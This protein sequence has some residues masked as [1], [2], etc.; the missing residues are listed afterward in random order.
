[1]R[2][3]TITSAESAGGSEPINLTWT[4]L[5]LQ[6]RNLRLRR[7]LAFATFALSVAFAGLVALADWRITVAA[8][9]LVLAAMPRFARR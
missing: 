9:L 2:T 6:R 8:W 4:I 7:M 5:V 1:M 3:S